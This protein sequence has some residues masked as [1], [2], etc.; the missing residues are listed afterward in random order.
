MRRRH[1]AA[2]AVLLLPLPAL[3]QAGRNDRQKYEVGAQYSSF[4]FD[5][6]RPI[7]RG[8]VSDPREGK[9]L[10]RPGVGG[11]F[12]YNLSD[13][14]AVEGEV[15]F[16]IGET[17]SF[18]PQGAGGRAVQAVGGIKAGRRFER[19]GIFAKGRPGIVSFSEGRLP[20]VPR[21]RFNE[22]G[23]AIPLLERA[24]H[25]AVD[26]GGVIEYYPSRRF[27]VRFDAGDTMIRY[28][29]WEVPNTGSPPLSF[30]DEIRHNLQFSA[31]FG[32]RF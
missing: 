8:G 11:R 7:V 17:V 27:T 32:F 13:H 28:G 18:A 3:A 23:L 30:P 6:N 12:T 20:V 29:G 15:N 19:F 9:D 1:L 4:W 5:R 16:F 10:H 31:G 22:Q 21:F 25:L 24:T 26:V 14:L 2:I